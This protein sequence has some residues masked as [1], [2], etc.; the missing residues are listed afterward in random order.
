M[1]SYVVSECAC[2]SFT[3]TFSEEV[4]P[5]NSE[6]APAPRKE[7]S[8]NPTPPITE[9]IPPPKEQRPEDQKPVDPKP[10][11]HDPE[12]RPDD[13]NIIPQT[14]EQDKEQETR[15]PIDYVPE[16]PRYIAPLYTTPEPTEPPVTTPEPTPSPEISYSEPNGTPDNPDIVFEPNSEPPQHRETPNSTYY[17][18]KPDKPVSS[19]EISPEIHENPTEKAPETVDPITERQP[20]VP[21]PTY[22]PYRPTAR[23][24]SPPA[25]PVVVRVEEETATEPRENNAGQTNVNVRPNDCPPGFEASD[26]GGCFGKFG[27]NLLFY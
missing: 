8:P 23:P 27:L 3:L 18:T 24:Y 19:N 16:V 2:N 10:V 1:S 20:E 13:N 5:V 11:D 17:E 26:N 21:R 7:P 14:N 9:V 6:T 15:K 22:S 4:D 25:D 12:T